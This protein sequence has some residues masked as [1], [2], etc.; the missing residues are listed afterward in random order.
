[1]VRYKRISEQEAML[2]NTI[3]AE[4][5]TEAIDH[6]MQKMILLKSFE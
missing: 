1:M 4:T 5:L 3:F 2:G 6:V